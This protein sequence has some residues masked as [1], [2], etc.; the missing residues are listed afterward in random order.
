[1]EKL[2]PTVSPN[3]M[4]TASSRLSPGL[5]ACVDV[6]AGVG[7]GVGVER[8]VVAAL[9]GISVVGASLISVTAQADTTRAQ[10]AK[11][12]TIETPRETARNLGIDN[13]YQPSV[14]PGVSES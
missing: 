9:D 14:T 7:R 3:F 13:L 5:G 4:V 8:G 12:P 1:M 2:D 11:M 6:G 10:T